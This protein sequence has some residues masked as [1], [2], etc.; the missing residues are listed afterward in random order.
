[1]LYE[2]HADWVAKAYVK[3][4]E[5]LEKLGQRTDAVKTYREML[6][7]EP[8]LALPEATVARQELARLGGGS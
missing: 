7:K 4:A 8:L 6:S 5:C 2:G 3:S 1:V